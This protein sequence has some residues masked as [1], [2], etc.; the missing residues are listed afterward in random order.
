[1]LKLGCMCGQTRRS[2]VREPL[3]SFGMVTA[4]G[5]LGALETFNISAACVDKTIGEG[6]KRIYF[7]SHVPAPGSG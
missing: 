4:D 5:L 7:A 1:M 2:E 6:K 3:K